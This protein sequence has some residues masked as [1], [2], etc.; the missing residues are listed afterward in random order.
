MLR[1]L[2]NTATA[3]KTELVRVQLKIASNESL[4]S[5]QKRKLPIETIVSAKTPKHANEIDTGKE[6]ATPTRKSA[7]VSSQ[8]KPVYDS[9]SESEANPLEVLSLPKNVKIIYSS[10]EKHTNK[11]LEGK[12]CKLIGLDAEWKVSFKKGEPQRPIG[13]LQLFFPSSNTVLLLHLVHMKIFPDRLKD[14]LQDPKIIKTGVNIIGDA[15]KMHRDYQVAMN[16]VL[17]IRRLLRSNSGLADLLEHELGV[18][19]VKTKS[20]MSDWE[21]KPL[22]KDQSAY[23]ALDVYAGWKLGHESLI[24]RGLF[25]DNQYHWHLLTDELFH[26][27]A[28][29]AETIVPEATPAERIA[30]ETTPTEASETIS[31]HAIESVDLEFDAWNSSMLEELENQV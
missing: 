18:S 31:G 5:S 4:P 1:V 20:R 22:R 26:L 25:K 23:A 6:N 11:I 21:R 24:N 19:L 7:R 9:P 8:P 12:D 29:V 15:R 17:E 30:P 27:D 13:L 10:D 28:P 14:L 3:A 16:G 2:A